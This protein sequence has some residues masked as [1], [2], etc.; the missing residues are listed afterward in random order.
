M[1]VDAFWVAAS[2]L[3]SRGSVIVAAIVLTNSFNAT[4][5]AAYSY[6]QIT[7]SMVSSYVAM[8]LGVAASKYF[9][10]IDL[11]DKNNN[12][13][14]VGFIWILSII[15]S[16]VGVLALVLSYFFGVE[17]TAGVPLYT[18]ALGFAV[19]SSTIVPSGAVLGLNKYKQS[20][21][22]S[23]ACSF[24]LMLGIWH[25]AKIN[26]PI[27]AINSL[28]VAS[29]LQVIGE[30]Y[31]VI[32]VVGWGLLFN[33]KQ[34]SVENFRKIL[35]VSGVMFFVTLFTASG[36]WLVGQNIIKNEDGV[37]Q[38]SMY[39]IGMQWFS[40]GMFLP[41]I[42]G[43][44][45]FPKIVKLFYKNDSEPTEIRRLAFLSAGSSAIVAVV[46]AIFCIICSPWILKFYGKAY[47]LNLELMASFFIAA[48]IVAPA[49]TLGN[50]IIASGGHKKW[51]FLIGISF[52]G[53]ICAALFFVSRGAISGAIAH[54]FYG[55]IL[56]IGSIV[57]VANKTKGSV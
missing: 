26:S 47:S 3:F 56:L 13:S 16:I 46:V 10:E 7:I 34:F 9:A 45:V 11:N 1:I 35:S 33:R 48:V 42:I 4:D 17:S 39:V 6:Y 21:F 37:H 30:S 2:Q 20:T 28:V 29:F 40:L 5:F 14:P 31:I 55:S 22:I 8:G 12:K 51:L 44:V 32:K 18:Y 19:V 43:R 38:F 54:I 36:S 49:G 52:V 41:G 23:I 27:F 57:V 50:I 24:F 25:A 53:M 15:V